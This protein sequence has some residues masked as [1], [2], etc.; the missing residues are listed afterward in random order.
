MAHTATTFTGLV[1]RGRR[2]HVLHVGDSRAWH[3]RGDRLAQITVD[4]THSHP[5]RRH[6]LLRALGLED[7]LRMDHHELA[8]TEHDRLLLTSDGVHGVLSTRRLAGLLGARRSAQGDAEA[9]VEAALAAGGRIMQPL[10]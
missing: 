1:M 10:W 5:D 7:H 9:I 6:I 3:L 4:H 8:V 2:A